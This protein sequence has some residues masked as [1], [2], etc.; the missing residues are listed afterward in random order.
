M[1]RTA[2]HKARMLALKLQALERKTERQVFSFDELGIPFQASFANDKLMRGAF[3][4]GADWAQQEFLNSL[5]HD[6]T[7]KVPNAGKTILL[8]KV[9]GNDVGYVVC[10]AKTYRDLNKGKLFKFEKWLNIND[11]KGNKK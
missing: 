9:S 4:C 11:L 10:R 5:W 3:I 2:I 6:K 8:A 7:E 1:N